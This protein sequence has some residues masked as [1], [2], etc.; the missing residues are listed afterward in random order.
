MTDLFLGKCR[1]CGQDVFYQ[2]GQTYVHC[3]ACGETLA[4]AGFLNEQI[5]ISRIQEE[6]EKTLAELKKAEE[7]KKKAEERLYQT[8]S[9]LGET[10]TAHARQ[11]DL[12]EQLK[13]GQEEAGADL[14]SL[15]ELTEALQDDQNRSID[16]LGVLYSRV[17]EGQDSSEEALNA[18]QS[19]TKILQSSES[20]LQ[21]KTDEIAGFLKTDAAEKTALL[22]ELKAWLQ[23]TN[24]EN[25]RRLDRIGE[26]LDRLAKE[27]EQRDR[28]LEELRRNADETKAAIENFEKRWHQK[29][30]N[31]ITQLYRQAE[32]YQFERQ[33]DKAENYYRQVL[34]N[35]GDDPEVCW[36]I[37]LCHYCVEYQLDNEGN[38]IASI[39]YPDL[40]DPS[41]IEDRKRLL[42][43]FQTKE[44]EAYYT[45]QL[46]VIDRALEKYRRLCKEV[47]YD[48]FISVKQRDKGKYTPDCAKAYELYR[49][50]R[51][52]LGLRVFNSEQTR[53]PAGEEFEPYIL[54]ALLSSRVMIVVGSC[55]EYMESQWIRNEWS[56]Y[57][58]LQKHE[59]INGEGRDRKLFCYLVNGMQSDQM[60][61]EL[62]NIQAIEEGVHAKEEL[63]RA[64]KPLLADKPASTAQDNTL[65]EQ[66]KQTSEPEKTDKKPVR[67]NTAYILIGLLVVLAVG[68]LM[69]VLGQNMPA[70]KQKP[71]ALT[72]AV[73]ATDT[74]VVTSTPTSTPTET[75]TP[76]LTPTETP[77][78]SATQTPTEL[79]TKAPTPTPTGTPTPE[80]TSTPP[81]IEY[82]EDGR[83]KKLY[84][85]NSDWS[86]RKNTYYDTDNNYRIYEYDQTGNITK[87][88]AYYADGTFDNCQSFEYDE[89]GRETKFYF[90][91][92]NGNVESET[93]YE[94]D[95]NNKRVRSIYK[96]NDST[97]I[98]EY[99]TSGQIIRENSNHADG[100]FASSRT[101]EYD[102]DGNLMQESFRT[103]DYS[104]IKEYDNRGQVIRENTDHADGSFSSS[105]SYEYD[106]D[107]NLVR[108]ISRTDNFITTK[109]YNTSGQVIRETTNHPD[110]SFSSGYSY[111]YDGDG[112]NIVRNY[113]A[114]DG[115]I[116]Q[117]YLYEYND[118]GKRTRS[119][120]YKSDGTIMSRS[121]YDDQGHE[122][123]Y[124][125]YQGGIKT[126]E[127]HYRYPENGKRLEKKIFYN[128]DGTIRSE[129]DWE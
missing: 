40:R 57:K 54:A 30:L 48:V 10:E 62:L 99:N 41:E 59:K 38:R 72:P 64:L 52:E 15:L 75:P 73:T 66:P 92:E 106:N 36:R 58:W 18:L 6:K 85:Y 127:R 100:S 103:E 51:D 47:R 84:E 90:L 44:Q 23:Q 9:D 3:T 7:E 97:T 118:S 79:P 39:L 34:I 5:R 67:K 112:R 125:Y 70:Q 19:V 55:R 120:W 124:V 14:N 113:L 93:T 87:M 21:K 114:E 126:I 116:K 29:E 1:Y 53:P 17:M 98:R 91:D 43:S 60:P 26:A 128:T 71:E 49:Y 20:D 37:V 50:I 35:G 80:P 89:L 45:A 94:Y 105:K 88:T 83:I 4:V 123:L 69:F 74:P 110:G 42:N 86:L 102:N 16:F 63:K 46:Q 2:D 101:Y 111:E 78:P 96:Q 24:Q 61:D 109:E 115:S 121:D 122:I 108:E 76:T 22:A 119:S 56:R 68:I 27:N 104:T 25:S 8:L 31:K 77:T 129:S 12:L 107:D 95:N 33:F 65:P 28:Q 81:Q 82:Y 11:Q 13:N 32:S 117:Y